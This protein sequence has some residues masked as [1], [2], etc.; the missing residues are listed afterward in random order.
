[1]LGWIEILMGSKPK[2]KDESH[3]PGKTSASSPEKGKSGA[4]N[5]KPDAAKKPQGD[6]G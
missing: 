1:M 4:S 5:S 2:D 3:A 6:A